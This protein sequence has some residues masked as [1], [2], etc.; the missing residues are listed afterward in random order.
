M[1]SSDQREVVR[2]IVENP[3][4]HVL[5]HG[6][7]G[8]GKSYVRDMCV[9]QCGG[10]NTIVVGPTGL[11][12]DAV[13]TRHAYTL[14]R[15]LN[16]CSE[17]GKG[18]VVDV[19]LLRRSQVV[20]EEAGMVSPR[21]WVALDQTL[22]DVLGHPHVPFGGVR[23]VLFCDLLQLRPVDGHYFW[24]L[25]T[26]QPPR[27][28]MTVFELTTNHRIGTQDREAAEEFENFLDVLR[29]HR[30]CGRAHGLL[31]YYFNRRNVPE[32]VLRLCSTQARAEEHNKHMLA[33]ST[34]ERYVFQNVRKE[35]VETYLELKLD[36]P[37]QITR[38][39][40]DPDDHVLLAV[41]GTFGVF[42]GVEDDE[43]LEEVDPGMIVCRPKSTMVVLV[44]HGNNTRRIP[45]VE[46][47]DALCYRFPVR[48]AYAATIH[49]V[50]GQTMDAVCVDGAQ[51]FDPQQLY[52][53]CSRV[54]SM[55]HLY[56]K[57]V[58]YESIVNPRLEIDPEITRFLAMNKLA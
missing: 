29:T 56:V 2:F 34:A 11:S 53:A 9:E 21:E 50:Q 7:A 32:N 24:N 18:V 48:L 41:N 45:L 26:F 58:P 43:T 38:N 13:R 42:G 8:V 44:R 28:A 57:N 4:T 40:Y 55:N 10:V 52:T 12:I 27:F 19:G 31:H 51:M 22:R 25:P 3:G 20:V 54:R 5:V 35:G 23:L 15:F 39:I 47:R 16:G 37:V 17:G 30:A 6:R 1:A 14:C 46:D 33:K 36:A 49:R